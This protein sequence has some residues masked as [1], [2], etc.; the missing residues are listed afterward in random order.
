MG[1]LFWG[2]YFTYRITRTRTQGHA[3]TQTHARTLRNTHRR[4]HE[5]T[6]FFGFILHIVPHAYT[7]AHAHIHT[8][9]FTHTHI[10]YVYSYFLILFYTS[11]R[12]LTHTTHTH[13]RMHAPH[14]TNTHT[15][16]FRMKAICHCVCISRL[17]R[18]EDQEHILNYISI[19]SIR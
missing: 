14:Y 2:F 16:G 15:Q 13:E 7:V 6:L 4:M 17:W 1:T 3:Q 11:Y 9:F 18:K 19:N 12:M 8:I 10:T 5:C